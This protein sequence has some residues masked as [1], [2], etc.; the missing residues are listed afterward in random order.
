MSV[1]GHPLTTK[2]TV[3]GLITLSLNRPTGPIQSLSPD[4]RLSVCLFV[5]RR[6]PM[7]FFLGLSLANY[8]DMISFQACRWSMSAAV[9]P[10]NRRGEENLAISIFNI[11]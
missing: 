1:L 7:Q 8:G 2:P 3:I 9:Q 5:C 11:Y 10:L 6:H 4:V